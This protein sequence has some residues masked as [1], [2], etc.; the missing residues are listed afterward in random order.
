MT[1]R[2]DYQRIFGEHLDDDFE[3]LFAPGPPPDRQQIAAFCQSIDCDLPEDYVCLLANDINGL[4]VEARESAWPRKRGGRA[5]ML[6]H[7]LVVYGLDA[8]LPDW[9]NL[10]E[11][12]GPFRHETGTALTPCMKAIGSADPYCFDR[13]GRLLRWDHES[14]GAASAGKT[15]FESVEDELRRL[16]TNKDRMRA[17]KP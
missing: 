10:R 6:Q 1:D 5:W 2:A 14:R 12:V 17:A 11:Q 7:G 16:R 8:G 3:I 4:Y 13:E 15:F 9:I